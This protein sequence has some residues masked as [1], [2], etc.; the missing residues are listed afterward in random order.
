MLPPNDAAV[1]DPERSFPPTPSPCLSN[2]VSIATVACQHHL[3]PAD[4]QISDTSTETVHVDLTLSGPP[5]SDASVVATLPGFFA[6]NDMSSAAACTLE[7]EHAPPSGEIDEQ[8]ELR[9]L[10]DQFISAALFQ[11]F[12]TFS[13]DFFDFNIII[14][15]FCRV[16]KLILSLK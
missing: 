12:Q 10:S 11:L 2:S 3:L 15:K 7:H 13:F 8:D 5:L 9:D 6:A 14:Y 16:I 1:V 4:A